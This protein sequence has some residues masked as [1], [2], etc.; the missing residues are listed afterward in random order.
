MEDEKPIGILLSL[1]KLAPLQKEILSTQC[2]T[3]EL[4]QESRP[5]CR[6]IQNYNKGGNIPENVWVYGAGDRPKCVSHVPH[7]GLEKP[8]VC[9]RGDLTEPIK[10]GFKRVVLYHP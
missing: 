10:D 5:T 3:C 9:K 2:Q 1:K 8:T 4:Y 7:V 6:H